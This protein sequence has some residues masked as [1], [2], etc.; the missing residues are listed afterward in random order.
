M[1]GSIMLYSAPAC[2][3][4]CSIWAGHIIVSH[5]LKAVMLKM[6]VHGNTTYNVL[7]AKV[8]LV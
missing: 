3:T 7:G 2:G 5:T 8:L 6:R 1:T 4:I